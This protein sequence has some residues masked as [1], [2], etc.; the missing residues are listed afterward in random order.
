MRRALVQLW[1]SHERCVAAAI[2]EPIGAEMWC[3]AL[4]S[5]LP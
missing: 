4:A 3:T 2:R 1:V 5:T